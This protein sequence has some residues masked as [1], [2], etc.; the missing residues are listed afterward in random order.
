M[1]RGASAGIV[2]VTTSDTG[3]SQSEGSLKPPKVIAADGI[4]A[5]TAV[6]PSTAA[7][8]NGT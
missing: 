6:K 8:A 5:P 1:N 4:V 7:V 3:R 2:N